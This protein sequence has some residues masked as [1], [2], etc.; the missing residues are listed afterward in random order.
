MAPN[1]SER[2]ACYRAAVAAL[3]PAPT[4]SGPPASPID[5][6]ETGPLEAIWLGRMAYREAWALQKRFAA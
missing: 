3:A 5:E 4:L 2:L 1:G 6:P